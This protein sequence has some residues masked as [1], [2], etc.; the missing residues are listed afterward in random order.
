MI[1]QPIMLVLSLVLLVAAV[2]T[3]LLRAEFFL[4]SGL[5][6]GAVEQITST[7]ERCGRKRSTSD[8]TRFEAVVG[9]RVRD[10]S[11]TTTYRA[12]TARGHGR[13]TSEAG[14]RVGT[15]Y[16]VRYSHR[17]PDNSCVNSPIEVWGAPIGLAVGQLIT[18]FSSF[19][20]GRRRW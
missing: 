11:Y 13:P 6:D 16:E 2:G 18:L 9:F 12:G 3:F 20:E 15:R 4:T 1:K 17:N 5:V 10:R 7:N 19:F 8:C 14:V